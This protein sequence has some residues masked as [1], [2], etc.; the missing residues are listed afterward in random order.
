M[1][2]A[3]A[4]P[5]SRSEFLDWVQSRD[6][7]YEFGGGR[8]VAMTG[9]SLRHNQIT[10]AIHRALDRHLAG[11]PCRPL[12]PGA[13]VATTADIIRY[14]DAVVTCSPFNRSE[15]LV[16]APVVVFEVVSP[17]SLRLDRVVKLREYQAVSSI[18]AYVI[19]ESEALAVTILPRDHDDETFRAAGLTEGDELVL[20]AFNVSVPVIEIYAA[21]DFG[22]VAGS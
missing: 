2:G 20:A 11:G 18:R 8:P 5:M 16:P 6:R 1:S 21:I 15:H 3:L 22:T 13:G 19:V 7:R 17:G 9:G 4:K 14:P 12:G 10:L